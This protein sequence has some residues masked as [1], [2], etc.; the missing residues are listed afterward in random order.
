MTGMDGL[1]IYMSFHDREI[2]GHHFTWE[3]T[4]TYQ[5]SDCIFFDDVQLNTANYMAEPCEP[6]SPIS[7]GGEYIRVW[8][9]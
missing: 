6:Q 3:Y 9:L 2:L 1:L 5:A 7:M 4:S 8:I